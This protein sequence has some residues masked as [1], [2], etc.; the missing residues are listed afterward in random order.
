MKRVT[1]AVFVLFVAFAAEPGCRRRSVVRDE[2][3]F[4]LEPTVPHILY[5]PAC[6]K[7]EI[8]FTTKDNALVN[9]YLM[10]KADGEE[11][12]SASALKGN[13]MAK[14]DNVST[15]RLVSPATENKVELAVVFISNKRA[16]VTA[17]ISGE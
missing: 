14:Q 3:T 1:I 9:A 13:P 15:G 16:N 5:V 2:K 10:S 7:C 12:E 11:T 6:K 17:R 8:N 4:D